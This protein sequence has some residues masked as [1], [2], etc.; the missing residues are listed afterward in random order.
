M[1]H[2]PK[3][4]VTFFFADIED[5]TQLIKRLGE[6][7]PYLL[8]K[9][10]QS[11]RSALEKLHG[12]EIDTAGDG[13]FAAF[14]TPAMAIHGA[15]MA[16]WAFYAQPWARKAGLKVRIGIHSGEAV[17]VPSGYIGLEVHRASRVCNAAHGGQVLLSQATIQSLKG[18]FNEG[19]LSFQDLGE[20]ILRGFEQPERLYQ[21]IIPGIPVNFPPPRTE[22]PSPSVAVLPFTN[23]SGSPEQDYFGDGMAEEI[24]IALNK[25]PGLRVVARSSSFALKGQPLSIRELGKQL[26]AKAILAGS[27]KKANGQVRVLAELVD[28]ETGY[29]LWAGKFERELSDLFTVQDE[30][31]QNIATALKIKLISKRVRDIKS[32][33]SSDIHAYDRYLKG[34]QYFYQFSPE[35][36]QKALQ[37]FQEAIEQDDAYALAYCGLANCYAYLY[38]Y[39]DNLEEY[40]LA[41][42]RASRR[43][44]ELDPLLP[45]A[46]VAYGHSLSLENRY[47]EAEGAFEQALELDPKLFEA[48]YLFARL[49]YAQGKLEKAAYW[50][51]EANR[52]RPEDYQ[53]LL[54]AGHVYAGLGKKDKAI[55][56]QRRGL[57]V[58]ESWLLLDPLDLRAL[59]LGANGLASLGEKGKALEW[60]QRAL[61]LRPDDPMLLYNAG[62]VYAI[63]GMT[64]EAL[65]CLEHA[66]EEGITQWG[67]YANDSNLKGL[68]KHP[69]FQALLQKMSPS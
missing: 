6:G 58:A 11:I 54:L 67:W 57:E 45:E 24:I 20:F 21:L 10:H 5:S 18:T 69:R 48:R 43:A 42:G 1:N 41:A 55:A 27:V 38:M 29:N 26:S 4:S 2:L 47:E 8:E 59:Y 60:L 19:S 28:S 39:V 37:L 53:S 46:F 56:A 32:R 35:S 51:E 22:T 14:P 68:R 33:H 7:Y 31:A 9:Y 63:L 62:C 44:I 49:Y 3:Q 65:S 15:V 13:F 25:V 12:E 16:Q 36:I 64:E 23:L 52:V 34:R 50:F 61:S 30:I 17:A 66:Y 40:L